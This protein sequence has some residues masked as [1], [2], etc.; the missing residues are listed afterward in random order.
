MFG[1]DKIGSVFDPARG[2]FLPVDTERAKTKLRLKE[3]AVEDGEHDIPHSDDE[4][5]SAVVTEIDVYLGNMIA[6]AKEKLIDRLKAIAKITASQSQTVGAAARE[7]S[8]IYEETKGKLIADAEYYRGDLLN[9]KNEKVRAHKELTDYRNTHERV[10]P[11]HYPESKVMAFGLIF[12]FAFI[13]IMVNAYA[14]GSSHPEGPL[15]V[16]IE[17]FMFTVV[18]IGVAFLLGYYVWRWF[19]HQSILRNVRSYILAPLMILFLLFINFLLAHYRDAISKLAARDLEYLDTL[20]SM[21]QLG[22]EALNN[23]IMSPLSLADFKSFLLL[24]VGLLAA[25]VAAIKS[26]GMDDPYPGYGKIQR[27]QVGLTEV[28]NEK[29]DAYLQEINELVDGCSKQINERLASLQGHVTALKQRKGDSELMLKKYQN[30][31]TTV[32]TAGKALYAFYRRENMKARESKT[33]PICFNR[34][35]YRLPDNAIVREEEIP[36]LPLDG[37]LPVDYAQIADIAEKNLKDLNEHRGKYQKEFEKM[38]S[39]TDEFFDEPYQEP[40]VFRE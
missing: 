29:Q 40:D 39:K 16:G 11:A 9:A 2:E 33:M 25:A 3:R 35:D 7:I 22:G 15:G 38:G 28:F 10:G 37:D 36:S 17:I 32:E 12:L 34:H 14:L 13:E 21:Q 30:W 19:H 31:L 8:Q 24:V 26:F 5:K 27:K 23:L 4:Q 18:N 1:M 20:N 6:R